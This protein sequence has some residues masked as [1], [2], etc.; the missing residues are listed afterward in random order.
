MFQGWRRYRD[1][2]VR[3][4]LRARNPRRFGPKT[5]RELTARLG[6]ASPRLSAFEI[7]E[8]RYSSSGGQLVSISRVARV[9]ETVFIETGIWDSSILQGTR[10]GGP[11][12]YRRNC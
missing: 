4:I 11:H 1:I 6:S 7:F 10:K 12:Q 5:Q 3:A 9:Y 2:A 8:L